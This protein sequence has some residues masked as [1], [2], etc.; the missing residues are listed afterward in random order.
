MK[1]I[2]T[3]LKVKRLDEHAQLP[4]RATNDAAGYDLTS[5]REVI[6]RGGET[7]V[8]PTGISI[9]VPTG[10]YGRIAPR[11]S[12]AA[13]HSIGVG[14]GVVDAGYRGEVKVV[15][16]NHGKEN[17]VVNIGDRIA[18]LVIECIETPLVEE[19][20]TLDDTERGENGFGSTGR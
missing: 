13:H 12:L 9:S 17:V 19:V 2:Q 8:V 6:V 3:I 10:T 18:Q 1:M 11:S 16:F 7:A 15:L 5:T 14:A 4:R 20:D